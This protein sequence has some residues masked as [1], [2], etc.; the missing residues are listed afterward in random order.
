MLAQA[1]LRVTANRQAPHVEV[2]A[3][4]AA[5]DNGG[6]LNLTLKSKTDTGT[7]APYL[8]GRIFVQWTEPDS[9]IGWN[10]Y[11]FGTGEKSDNAPAQVAAFLTD[12]GGNAHGLSCQSQT[13]RRLRR[14]CARRSITVR[15]DPAA[16]ALDPD[17]LSLPV[18]PD[19]YVV[20][21]KPFAPDGKFA[22]NSL[23]RASMS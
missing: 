10:D 16:G 18:R 6:D 9:F 21:I 3:D 22:E 23:T 12:A 20:G 2:T 7:T 1:P 11:R 8:S 19:N 4:R 13:S 14:P 15:S 5:L 17:P